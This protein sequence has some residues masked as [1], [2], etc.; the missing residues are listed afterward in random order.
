MHFSFVSYMNAFVL[1]FVKVFII[2]EQQHSAVLHIFKDK[3]FSSA[4]ADL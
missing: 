2:N 3:V 1:W 4:K